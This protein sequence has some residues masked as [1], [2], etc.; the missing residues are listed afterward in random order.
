MNQAASALPSLQPI[1][2]LRVIPA[3][4]PAPPSSFPCPHL[5]PLSYFQTVRLFAFLAPAVSNPNVPAA[6]VTP[7]PSPIHLSLTHEV[8]KAFTSMAYF[9]RDPT[10]FVT[11]AN[12][13]SV[14]LF[15]T[16]R[17]GDPIHSLLRLMHGLYVPA[18]V[19]NTTWPETV[20]SDFTAQM[21][22]FMATL[23]ETVHEVH[24]K[25]IL[26][27]PKVGVGQAAGLEGYDCG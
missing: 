6:A 21:H 16:L 2:T 24:G 13:G 4:K 11:E 1:L 8:P 22:K 23:T 7:D 26:Y 14:I 25:T 27:I 18:V 19:S 17:D 10:K 9:V 20:R 15:G 5:L 3:A 12:I